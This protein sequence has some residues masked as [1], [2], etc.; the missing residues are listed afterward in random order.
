MGAAPSTNKTHFL[1]LNSG[2]SE[3]EQTLN[4]WSDKFDTRCVKCKVNR[5]AAQV[6]EPC[7]APP[8]AEKQLLSVQMPK[9]LQS[10]DTVRVAFFRE[11]LPHTRAP[12]T[13]WLP[14]DWSVSPNYKE[15]L[16]HELIHIHQR[17]NPDFW[18]DLY[19]RK[20]DM[21]PFDGRLPAEIEARRRFNPD[22]VQAPLYIWRDE[23]IPV[24]VFLRPDAPHLREIRLLFVHK[25][26]GWQAVPPAEWTGFFGTADASI[27]EHPHEM[28]A[29]M[30][31]H[32][33]T[34]SLA[35]KLAIDFIQN[36]QT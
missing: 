32:D 13:I 34:T 18:K 11:G 36:Q 26:G 25:T 30:L 20:W 24:A 27:C 21:V 28:A 6:V 23:W 17:K 7:A 3:N 29:Y 22:T 19:G 16:I 35:K 15:T 12:N 31:T 10:L 1:I 14:Y 2:E 8:P 5:R 9:W 33:G 4:D